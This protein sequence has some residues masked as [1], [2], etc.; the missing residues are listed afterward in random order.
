MEKIHCTLP[1]TVIQDRAV[2][3]DTPDRGVIR[4]IRIY[5]QG[6]HG[7]PVDVKIK[8]YSHP[9]APPASPL[10]AASDD[11][12]AVTAAAA[13]ELFA[14]TPQY[15]ILAADAYMVQLGLDLHYTNRRRGSTGNAR[16]LYLA[17]DAA[18]GGRQWLV[19]LDITEA[20]LL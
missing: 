5:R 20:Q 3:L 10:V 2:K 16:E 15:T 1:L 11:D 13:P 19:S 4:A 18:V 6:V 12:M 7:S 14:V 8:L 9:S 17:F